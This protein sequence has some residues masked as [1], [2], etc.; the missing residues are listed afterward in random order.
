MSIDVIVTSDKSARLIVTVSG[1]D[2]D[3]LMSVYR[4]DGQDRI[5]VLGAVNI[6]AASTVL[7]D[8]AVGLNRPI[9]WTVQFDDGTGF[10]TEPVTVPATLPILSDPYTGAQTELMAV[11]WDDELT[12]QARVEVFAIEG[13][14][15]PVAVPDVPTGY[16]SPL[17][18]LTLDLDAADTV[19]DLARTAAPLLLRCSCG[20]HKD[21]WIQPVSNLLR[22]RLVQKPSLAARLHSWDSCLYLQGPP[23]VLKRA[24]FDTLA[25]LHD[26]VPTTLGDIAE[27]WA[28][29]GD[30]A[31]TDL[32]EGI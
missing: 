6:P 32:S 22:A 27:T 3:A 16:Y 2:P 15:Q 5:P 23:N 10:T 25:E 7:I 17:Q 11:V 12:L 30:I 19:T 28:T 29:L 20:Q 24:A 31:A 9:S 8:A 4:V 18:L 26:A 21:R 14:P 1:A 13:S